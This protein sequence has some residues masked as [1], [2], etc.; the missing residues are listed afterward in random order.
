MS[1]LPNLQ[2]STISIK[3][4]MTFFT[5]IE[6]FLKIFGMAKVPNSQNNLEKKEQ[7]SRHQTFRFQ[8]LLQSYSNQNSK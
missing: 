5:E 6:K 4:L 3:I 2:F 8:I 7:S 1:I